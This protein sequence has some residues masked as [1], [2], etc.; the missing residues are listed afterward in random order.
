MVAGFLFFNAIGAITLGGRRQFGQC[1]ILQGG[2]L[3]DHGKVTR[4][5]QPVVDIA[6]LAGGNDDPCLAQCHQMLGEI[7][8]T[9]AEGG[10]QVAD[11]RFALANGQ[12][13]LQPGSLTDGLEQ[14]GHFFNRGYIRHGEY[15]IPF[16]N[17]PGSAECHVHRRR[18]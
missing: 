9:P 18:M 6:P 7:S 1:H 13:D 2:G 12:Q 8:L 5:A 3:P 15:I 16:D 10:L 17:S 4:V 14:R 11:A